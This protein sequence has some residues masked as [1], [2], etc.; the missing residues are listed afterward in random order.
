MFSVFK[1]SRSRYY[2][3]RSYLGSKREHVQT[4]QMLDDIKQHEG[5]KIELGGTQ[6][7]SSAQLDPDNE[8]L[9]YRKNLSGWGIKKIICL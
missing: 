4:L 9:Y 6:L 7:V 5:K 2:E 1:V 8:D 3:W